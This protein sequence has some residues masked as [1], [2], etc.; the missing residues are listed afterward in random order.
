MGRTKDR[1]LYKRNNL[2]ESITYAKKY[3]AGGYVRLSNS[4]ENKESESIENQ[5]YLINLFIQEHPD[6][7]LQ[8]FYEDDGYTGTNF[9]RSGFKEMME[10]VRCGRINCIIVKDI[11]R[12]GREYIQVGDYLEKVFPFLGVRFISLLDHY[13]SFDPNSN[14]EHM[15]LTIKSLF[16]DIYPRDISEK[17]HTSFR[18]KFERGEAG[19]KA[20]CTYGYR[21]LPN[22][23]RYR[24]DYRTYRIYKKIVGWYVAGNSTRKIVFI[25]FKKGILTPMQYKETGKVYQDEN[26][27]A[28]L[29]AESVIFKMLR[30]SEYEGTLILHKTEQSLY[31]NIPPHAVDTSELKIIKNAH[32]AILSHERFAWLQNIIAERSNKYEKQELPIW[33]SLDEKIFKGYLYCGECGASMKRRSQNKW[34]GGVKYRTYGYACSSNEIMRE[35]CSRKWICEYELCDIVMKALS[36]RFLQMQDLNRLLDTYCRDNYSKIFALMDK[37]M[38]TVRKNKQKLELNRM[39][40]YT[41]YLEKK[42][43]VCSLELFKSRYLKMRREY[44][45]KEQELIDNV[46]RFRKMQK[47]QIRMVSEFLKYKREL[48]FSRKE[49]YCRISSEVINTFIKRI[50]FFDNKRIEIVFTFED[51]FTYLTQYAKQLEKEGDV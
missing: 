4:S 32:P 12:F 34:V 49:A 1:Y 16:H 37:E 24:I 15:M 14:S 27:K 9:I 5:K 26:V 7:Q 47:L 40:V 31:E 42:I 43:D 35:L 46:E 13:D 10:A 25:L 30:N 6:I 28:E 29:W 50:L 44:D 21:M 39:Q 3:W 33:K 18:K 11:S 45:G 38:R 20:F 41:E 22:D 17:V 51:E 8:S 2:F 48:F 19:R 36:I 23:T